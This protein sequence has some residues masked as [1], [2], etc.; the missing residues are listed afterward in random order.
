MIARL[1]GWLVLAR[2]NRSAFD[3]AVGQGVLYKR[4][5]RSSPVVCEV[6]QQSIAPSSKPEVM[7][8]CS[9]SVSFFPGLPSVSLLAKP[10][11]TGTWT[12]RFPTPTT[13]VKNSPPGPIF[14]TG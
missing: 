8:F 11:G 10:I 1:V 5:K 14:N 3:R 12:R 4:R 9:A 2:F 7:R 6:N 13:L